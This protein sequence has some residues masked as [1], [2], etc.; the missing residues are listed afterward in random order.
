MVQEV[1]TKTHVQESEVGEWWVF[2]TWDGERLIGPMR[3]REQAETV[4]SWLR[5]VATPGSFEACVERAR[6]VG[7]FA[8]EKRA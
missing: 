4:Q 3:L 1:T 5:N 8:A 2:R 6:R 7:E